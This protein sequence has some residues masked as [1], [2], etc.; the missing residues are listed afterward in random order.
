MSDKRAQSNAVYCQDRAGHNHPCGSVATGNAGSRELRLR[1]GR[2]SRAKR[3]AD[4]TCWS[5]RMLTCGQARMKKEVAEDRRLARITK[6]CLA[7]PE[8]TKERH[9]SHA[10]F[11]VRKKVFTY[12]LDNHHGDGIVAVN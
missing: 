1:V 9:G 8:S 2:R 7:L 6:I 3:N 10:S 11:R 4:L 12:Y 5:R